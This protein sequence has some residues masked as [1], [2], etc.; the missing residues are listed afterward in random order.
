MPHEVL[1]YKAIPM[2]PGLASVQAVIKLPKDAGI[3][4]SGKMMMSVWVPEAGRTPTRSPSSKQR[5]SSVLIVLT[6]GRE[7]RK[8][9]RYNS[10]LPVFFSISA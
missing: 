1:D 2:L 4:S 5:T 10:A 9:V 8:S 7:G 6:L 3:S